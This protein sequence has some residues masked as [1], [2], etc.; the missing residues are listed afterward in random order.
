M[1]V[2]ICMEGE[3]SMINAGDKIQVVFHM[4]TFLPQEI[5]VAEMKKST[6]EWDEAF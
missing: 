1:C 4:C 2:C 5:A 6:C 3:W